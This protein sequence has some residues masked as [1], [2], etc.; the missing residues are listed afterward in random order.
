MR[1]IFNRNNDGTYT[2]KGKKYEIITG[3]RAQVW[4]GTA[5]ETTGQLTKD[6]LVMNKHG[7]I[8]SKDKFNTSRKEMRLVKHGYGARKG[9]FGYVKLHSSRK[10]S[11][12][13]KLKK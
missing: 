3:T 7:R 4:H 1:S 6:D 2:I 13:R 8:V 12:T 10:S 11:K 5:Y 9:K